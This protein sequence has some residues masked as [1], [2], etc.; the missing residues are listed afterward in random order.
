M[1]AP[2]G[3][4]RSIFT[5]G[6]SRLSSEIRTSAGLSR[7]ISSISSV[8]IRLVS[9]NRPVDSSTQDRPNFPP[10]STTAAR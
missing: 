2:T 8:R 7:A 5:H 10:T 6:A 1:I 9:E 3:W 4:P